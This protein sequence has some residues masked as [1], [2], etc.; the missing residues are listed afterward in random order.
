MTVFA[1]AAASAATIAR[2]RV[3]ASTRSTSCADPPSLLFLL[4]TLGPALV[5]LAALD[6]RT[7]R[8]LRPA[9]VVGRVPL[10]CERQTAQRG[11]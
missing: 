8:V 11:G 1:S 2:R 6:A 5:L 10:V 9:H 4:M 3:G 7:P